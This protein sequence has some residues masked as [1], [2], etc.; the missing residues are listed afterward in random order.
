MYS[1]FEYC[2]V[3]ENERFILRLVSK[4]DA[5]DLLRVY[6]DKNA[7]PFFNSDNCNGNNFYYQ[8]LEKMAE[9]IDFWILEYEGKRYVRFSIVD[10]GLNE[11]IGTIELFK[12]IS[13]DSF[14]EAGIMSVDVRS[15]FEKKETLYEILMITTNAAFELFDFHQIATKAANYAVE[16]IEALKQMKYVKTNDRL[17]ASDGNSYGDYWIIER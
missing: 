17:I 10:K 2:P 13:K 3:I 14:N 7:L 16:R 12:R 11:V 1:I 9:L 4:E 6:S 15:D 5:K 8:T